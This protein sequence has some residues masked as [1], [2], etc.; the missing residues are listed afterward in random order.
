MARPQGG[1][2]EGVAEG[3]TPTV[4]SSYDVL[5]EGHE[6]RVPFVVIVV[7]REDLPANCP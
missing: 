7:V 1:S 5:E 3:G 4:L 2:D 6:L